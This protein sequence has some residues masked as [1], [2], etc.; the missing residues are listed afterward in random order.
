M[1]FLEEKKILESSKK[2]AEKNG[3]RLN[4]DKKILNA[5]ISA[6]AK[7]REKHG[8]AYCPCRAL[9][10]NREED[11]K[12]ICPCAFHIEEIKRDGHCKCKLFL[13]KGE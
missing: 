13:G 10:G 8:F 1:I 5:V 11:K 9:T 7:N 3:F 12:N 4:P 2:Y 6:L